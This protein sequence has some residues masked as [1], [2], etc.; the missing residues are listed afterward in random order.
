VEVVGENPFAAADFPPT[1]AQAIRRLVLLR[2]SGDL[3]VFGA[4][5]GVRTFNFQEEFGGHGGAYREEQEAFMLSPPWVEFAFDKVTR[6][7]ELHPFFAR[8]RPA[9]EAPREPLPAAVAV[10]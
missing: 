3:V 4:R 6:A 10:G 8:Y 7:P 2:A 9:E 1:T 5:Q